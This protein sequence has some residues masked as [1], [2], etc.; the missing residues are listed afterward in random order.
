MDIEVKPDNWML[1]NRIGYNKYVYNTFHP[2]KY[3]NNNIKND[4]SKKLGCECDKGSC[5]L[6]IKSVSLFSQQR[7]IKDYMQFDSPYRGILL[8]HELGSGKSAASIAAAE[9]YINR[10]KIV[11]MTPASLS[12]NYENELM[13]ISKTGLNLKKS[14]TLLKVEKTNNEM[15]RILN[16]YAITDKII[17]KDGLVWVPLYNND[18]IGAEIIVEKTKYSAIPSKYKDNVDQTIAHII[19]N[20]YTFINYNGLTAKMIKDMGDSPFD[21][22]FVIIDEIHNFIS[23]IVNGSRL[24]RSIYNHMMNANNIKIVLLS[25][26]PIINQ[27]YEIATLI[28]LIRG[29]IIT[30]KIPIM[31]GRTNKEELIDTLEKSKHYNYIDELYL[32]DKNVNIVLFP[33]NFVRKDNEKS[34]IIKNDWVME[35]NAIIKDIINKVNNNDT[36]KKALSKNINLPN[37]KKPYLIVSNGITGAMKTKMVE[38]IINDLKLSTNNVKIN[39]DDLVVNNEEYK[40]RIL[41]I[42]NNVN[43]ECNNNKSCILDKYE[44][45]SEKLLE[46]F[47][48]AYYDVR[49][50]NKNIYCTPEIKKSC[51]LLLEDNLKKALKENKN[52]IFETQ[53][54]HPPKWLLSQIYLTDRYNVIYGYSFP[55]I[56]NSIDVIK[57]R[58]IARIDKFEKNQKMDAPRYPSIDKK[59]ITKNVNQIISVLKDIRNNCVNE[60]EI[61]ISNCGNKKIDKLLIYNPDNN[62]NFNLVYD[63]NY[64]NNM[65]ESDFEKLLNEIINDE[66]GDKKNNITLNKKYQIEKNYALPNKKEDF[67]KLFIND[68]DP[69]NIKI[70]N[71]DLF[72]RRVLGTLSYYKTTGSEFFPNVLPTNY[73]FLNMTNHQLNKYVEVRRKEMD[74][75]DRKKKFG[76]KGKADVNSVYRAFSRM[77]CNFVFPDNIKRAF[78]QDIRLIM[79][80]ELAKNAEDDYSKE[81]ED[82]K[83]INKAVATQYEKQLE[84]AMNELSKSDAINIDNLKELYSPKFA[85]MLKDMNESPGTVLVYS[86][87]RMVEGLGILKEVMN[88]NGYV[89]INIIKSEEFGY[90]IEDI[91]VFN[92]KYDNKRYVVF[93]SDRTKTNILM[94]L[95]NGD[96]SLLPDN[97]KIQIDGIEKIDQRY[98]KLVKTMMITQSGAEGI[99]LK[100]V[101]RVLITEY[102]WNSVRINQ[103]IGRA[104]RTCSHMS[105]PKEHQNVGVYIYIMKLTKEQL[106]NNPTLRKKDNEL[107]TDEHILYLAQKKEGLINSFLNMLKSSSIDCV[108]HSNKNKPLVNGYKC[109]NW[110]INVDDNKLSYT[111]NIN[112][113]NKIQQHQKYQK[114]IK[115]KGK[116][117]SK[118]GIKYVLLGDKIYDYDSYVN[119]GLLYL[120]NI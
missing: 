6:H 13:K 19:R 23:R 35:D 61:M 92:E 3:E 39:I 24:A 67:D 69:E 62:F 95:F 64:D 106:A 80:K 101:R 81:E 2:K 76:N 1:T 22:T 89:E 66:K 120:A 117:I 52:I 17:K 65:S 37:N 63:N 16:K 33:K 68:N 11:I 86:Q 72:K 21:D 60:D 40:K 46:D 53:G 100:N 57:K 90:I 112:T 110:P 20:R 79:K 71:E 48:K 29:P 54:L 74:M 7:I 26:T 109:Y 28:N 102:F 31:N 58:A 47:K 83:D 98:G 75:D 42:I 78:P 34:L 108:I 99:S 97:I 94:N 73:K 114:L 36:V 27:P 15:M 93:N 88:R 96:F 51:D 44:N 59:H 9:G 4:V 84:T 41:D 119:A 118:N 12:Q 10:K 111:E 43:K 45:P 113:D 32:D 50:G 30:Y 82:K 91:E 107:T 115:N 87:F 116:V 5:D 104:V 18:I 14:W 49:T 25:G 103:V 105:L 70:K 55:S 77:V 85:E 56:E 38:K 8:Y